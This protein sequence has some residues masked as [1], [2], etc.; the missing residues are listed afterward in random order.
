[1]AVRWNLGFPKI[2]KNLMKNTDQKNLSVNTLGQLPTPLDRPFK[3]S[4]FK[5]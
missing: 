5:V 4:D 3:L 2:N 1:M